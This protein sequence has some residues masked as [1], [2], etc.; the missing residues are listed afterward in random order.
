MKST[1]TAASI[2]VGWKANS[3]ACAAWLSDDITMS[4]RDTCTSMPTKPP[5]W[6]TTAAGQTVGW[7]LGWSLTR[8]ERPPAAR[9]RAIGSGGPKAC[10]NPYGAEPTYLVIAIRLWQYLVLREHS[11]RSGLY[12]CLP[13]LPHQPLAGWRCHHAIDS[14]WGARKVNPPSVNSCPKEGHTNG[15]LHRDLRP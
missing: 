7:S 9:G 1:A 15:K 3:P 4:A 10:R 2:P 5:C 11:G 12:T 14:E 6:K 8:W 13:Y